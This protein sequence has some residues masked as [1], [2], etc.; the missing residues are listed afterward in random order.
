LAIYP[1]I[2][3]DE[4]SFNWHRKEKI[5]QNSRVYVSTPSQWLMDKVKNSILRPAIV[6]AKVIP[7]GVDLEVFKRGHIEQ[8][9]K[10]LGLP[11]DSKVVLFVA[12]G[13]VRNV[14]KDFETMKKAI[15][16]VSNKQLDFRLLFV[17]L[18]DSEN[19]EFANS[20]DLKMIP[21]TI[22]TEEVASYYQAA[23]LYLH[24]ARAETFPNA[25]LEAFACGTPVVATAV[26]GI[27]EQIKGLRIP[28]RES[29]NANL[30][31]YEMEEATGLLTP[32]GD[33]EAMAEAIQYLL[34]HDEIRRKL[35]E[36]AAR[37]A[38]ERFDLQRQVDEYLDWYQEI[39]S[40][41]NDNKYTWRGSMKGIE[42]RETGCSF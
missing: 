27:P 41:W 32:P 24:A 10:C 6:D 18:G 34:E 5:Y 3:K 21:Y 16:L 26:G 42:N 17:T 38:R 37:D 25:I 13:V 29:R 36:N 8:S 4:T 35:S 20:L 1:A 19:S 9:K 12:D 33:A 11:I 31:K 28:N 39:F 2:T 30:N 15:I 14:M 23:D 7:N 22:R 40:V